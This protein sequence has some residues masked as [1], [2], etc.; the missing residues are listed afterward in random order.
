MDSNASAFQLVFTADPALMHIVGLSLAVSLTA[1][2][3]AA[4]IGLPLGA[5][6]APLLQA[7]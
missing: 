3:C 5:C 7:C 1:V 4:V 2:L 6:H